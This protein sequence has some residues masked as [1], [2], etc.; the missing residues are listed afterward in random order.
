MRADIQWW[1]V[2]I[3][4]CCRSFPFIPS[5][6]SISQRFLPPDEVHVSLLPMSQCPPSSLPPILDRSL[7]TS[8]LSFLHRS[9]Y[10][11]Q[12]WDTVFSPQL[13]SSISEPARAPFPPHLPAKV[14]P[15]IRT[16]RAG[17]GSFIKGKYSCKLKMMTLQL[18]FFL[19]K[20][21]HQLLPGT[22]CHIVP[23]PFLRVAST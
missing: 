21:N 14:K 4:P 17:L 10:S 18:M 9:D 8:L 12:T 3:A 6:L 7:A 15:D 19:S 23:P 13:F 2:T 1:F 22:R 5:S 16:K 20:P 11:Q